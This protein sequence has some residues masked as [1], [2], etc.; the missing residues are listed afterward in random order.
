MRAVALELRNA[1][2]TNRMRFLRVPRPG[3]ASADTSPCIFSKL[4]AEAPC[5]FWF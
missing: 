4:Q 5:T 2:L 3:L 1:L